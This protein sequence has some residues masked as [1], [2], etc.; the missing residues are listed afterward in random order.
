MGSDLEWL[1]DHPTRAEPDPFAGPDHPMR[2]MTR[3]VAFDRVWDERNAANVGELF[4]TLAEDWARHTEQP[5][6]LA[7][8]A[9]ALDRGGAPLDGGWLELG[10]GTGVGTSLARERIARLTVA[11]LSWEMLVRAPADL[12]PRVRADAA[13]LPFREDQFDGLLLVNMLLFPDEV[14]RV[15]AADGALVWVN[16]AGDQTPIHLPPD[17]VLDAL[18]G[19]WRGCAARAGT[20]IWL[21]AR[22]A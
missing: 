2:K 7:A 20:G 17:D 13:R 5:G 22:R 6:R 4:D 9:D 11:D 12:A 1:A 19:T 16:T 3:R 18:P 10:S 21:V 15:L 8:I 14:E